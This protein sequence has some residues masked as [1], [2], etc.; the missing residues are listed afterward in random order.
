MADEAAVLDAPTTDSGVIDTGSTDTSTVTSTTGDDTGS[1]G[2]VDTIDNADTPAEGEIGHLRG[3]ELYR[4]VKEKLKAA[5]LSPAEQRSLRNAIHIAAKA[6]AASGGDLTKF[7]T[8]RAAYAK[9]AFEGEETLA[10]EDLVQTVR[11]DREQLAGIL[12]DIASGAPKLVEELFTDHPESAKTLT[13]QAMDRLAELDNER[14]SNYVAK[15]AVNYM[16]SQGIDVEFAL[17]DAFLPSVPDFPGKKQ[18]VDAL[19]KIYG[20]IGGLKTL[21]SKQIANPNVK[22]GTPGA[23]DA[24]Q[25][26][27]LE[28]R[29]QN[30]RR[31]EWNQTAGQPNVQLRDS[32]MT[33]AAGARKITLTDAEKTKIR[34]AVRE[35][36][37]TRLAAN[38]Q[39]G[40]TMRGY[41]KNNNQRE[42]NKRAA[43]EGQKLLPSIVARHPNA[44]IDERA[45]TA[46]TTKPAPNGN[47][48]Q[49]TTT[50]TTKDSQG[51]AIQWLSGAPKTVGKQ[52]DY[53]RTSN[54]MLL[55]GEAYLKGEK[56]LFKWKSKTVLGN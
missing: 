34:S 50:T 5:G 25:G 45:R 28:I 21:A 6:D 39:Y 3:A 47:G 53:M 30:V 26:S 18:F 33:R 24:P 23:Q 15:S 42:Y 40:D 10:P 43:A 29:E 31:S 44:V 32:E 1:T 4:A 41:L 37:E 8:E 49:R 52:V 22:T 17:L 19:N 36:F 20:T 14:F 56:G 13:T 54:A 38:R 35:E 11:A 12:S 46:A 55:R 27:D 48:Q 9:L 16:Q 7:E 2:A 51:N